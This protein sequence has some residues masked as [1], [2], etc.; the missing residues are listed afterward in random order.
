MLGCIRN[1]AVGSFVFG[2]GGA[3]ESTGVDDSV[4]GLWVD[5]GAL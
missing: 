3:E 1:A 4:N 2:M 5:V